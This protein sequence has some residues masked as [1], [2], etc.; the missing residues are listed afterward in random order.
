MAY[1]PRASGLGHV[2]PYQVS[3]RPYITGSVVEN[4]DP[5]SAATA[6]FKISFPHVART[7]RIENTG[8]APLRIHFANATDDGNGAI[9][10]N[11][12]YIIPSGMLHYGSG[13][14]ANYITG[15][16]KNQPYEFNV[17]CVDLYVSSMNL[18]QSGFQLFAELTHIPFQDMYTLS[19]SGINAKT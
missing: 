3:G 17:K 5:T 10:E 9:S 4:G 8:S 6:Q 12:F 14:A 1:T 11:N 13:A 2:A 19:G 18:G 15:S 16:S 7:L